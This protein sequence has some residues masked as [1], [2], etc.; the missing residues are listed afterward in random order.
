MKKFLKT[1]IP[2]ELAKGLLLTGKRFGQVLFS[3]NRRKVKLHVVQEYPEVVAK[4]Q[5]R[6]RGRLQLIKD[7]QGELKCVCCMLC[8]KACPTNAIQII[9]GKKEGRK[10]RIPTS[11]DFELERCV[12]CGF[13]VE[14]CTFGA[15]SLNHQFELAVYNR[16]DLSLGLGGVFQS[17][18]K[19]SPVAKFS[20]SGEE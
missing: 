5:P 7:E 8:V 13:C 1:L 6:F 17:I 9:A 14:S 11:Y 15:I 12:F 18:D 3:A 10:T 19:P 20:Y 16:E 4:V 2:I